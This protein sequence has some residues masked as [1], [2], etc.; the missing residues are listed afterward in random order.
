MKNE[1]GM[2]QL[3]KEAC[4]M[5]KDRSKEEADLIYY[6]AKMEEDL[7]MAI[8]LAYQGLYDKSDAESTG[9]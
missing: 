9:S 4:E 7:R 2:F 5:L 8:V 6:V 3:V 1:T